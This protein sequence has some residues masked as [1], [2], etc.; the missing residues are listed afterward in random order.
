[1]KFTDLVEALKGGHKPVIAVVAPTGE[2]IY[3]AL[4][5]V[6]KEGLCS[7]LLVGDE[8]KI[9]EEV[10]EYGLKEYSILSSE[11]PA[12]DAVHAILEKNP[13]SQFESFY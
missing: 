10:K 11:K 4:K 5:E 7:F 13:Q 1:M 8:K 6:E 9:T 2:N 3:S 12:D